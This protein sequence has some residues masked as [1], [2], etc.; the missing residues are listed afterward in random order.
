MTAEFNPQSITTQL[1]FNLSI[2]PDAENGKEVRRKTW[3]KWLPLMIYGFG[4]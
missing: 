4:S 2:R 3:S 1:K